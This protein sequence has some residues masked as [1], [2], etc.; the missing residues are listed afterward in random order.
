M[1]IVYKEEL[2]NELIKLIDNSENFL[3][4]IS[5]YFDLLSEIE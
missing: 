3:Y 4:I 2:V 5:P 1:N